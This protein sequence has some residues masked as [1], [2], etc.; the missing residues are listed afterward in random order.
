[1]GP[2]GP[3]CYGI[4]T[5]SPRGM[6]VRMGEA[7]LGR[8]GSGSGSRGGRRAS[9]RSGGEKSIV[10]TDRAAGKCR[11]GLWGPWEEEL[12]ATC[13]VAMLR[14]RDSRRLSLAEG[15][16]EAQRR[17]SGRVRVAERPRDP[18]KLH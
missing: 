4:T 12:K 16:P 13:R 5:E 9:R 2:G 6:A 1:M 14:C 10:G 7:A 18:R 8:L 3:G 11:A 15:I 17:V